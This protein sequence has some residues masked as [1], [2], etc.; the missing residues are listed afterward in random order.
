MYTSSHLQISGSFSVIHLF[1][2]NQLN[3]LL[4]YHYVILV[5]S[6]FKF[7]HSKTQKLK[8]VLVGGNITQHQNKIHAGQTLVQTSF[9]AI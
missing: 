3:Q 5:A 7:I 1:Y 8:L 9:L 4:Y 6:S 2:F